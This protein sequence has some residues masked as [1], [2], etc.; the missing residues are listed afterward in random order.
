M[1]GSLVIGLGSGRSGTASLAS[2]IDRQRGGICFHE[3]NP[4]GAVFAGNP[5]AHLNTVRE[6]RSILDGGDRARLSIDYSRPASCDTYAKLQAMSEVRLI[7]DIAYYYLN[8]VGAILDVVPE[9]RF[10]C[11]RRDRAATVAS[12]LRKSAINRWPSLYI[13]DRIKSLLTRTPFHT[14]Y[15]YWQEHDGSVYRHDPVWDSCF[16]KIEA[17]SKEEAIGLYWDYY[18]LEAA[19]LQEIY[20]AALRIF[21]VEEMSSPEGQRRILEFVGLEDEDIVVSEEVHL[22]RTS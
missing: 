22:H 2:L 19:R 6:F 17:R 14:E 16:P 8:Y 20:P 10:V 7:G 1:S 21:E 11:I 12:W 15:N 5:Q 9:C 18:Y 4:A 13:A 3:M